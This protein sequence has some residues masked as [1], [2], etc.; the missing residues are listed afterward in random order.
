MTYVIPGELTTTPSSFHYFEFYRLI[1][2]GLQHF[3]LACWVQ[4]KGL[5]VMCSP[6]TR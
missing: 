4:G 1:K 2:D 6:L 3:K 5:V